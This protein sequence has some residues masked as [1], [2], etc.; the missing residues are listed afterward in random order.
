MGGGMLIVSAG[1]S[2]YEYRTND[3]KYYITSYMELVTSVDLLL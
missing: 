2:I 3:N 1:L